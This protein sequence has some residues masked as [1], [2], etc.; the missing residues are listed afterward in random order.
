[1]RTHMTRPRAIV[2]LMAITGLV[3]AVGL[4]QAS[5][6][7]P[8][9]LAA[10]DLA[11]GAIRFDTAAP[12]ASVHLHAIGPGVVVATGADNCDVAARE[13]AFA[14]SLPDGA[15]R[16]KR[17][18]RGACFDYS[19]T[20]SLAHGVVAVQ[21]RHGTS[22]WS[23]ED[24]SARWVVRALDAPKQAG[25][26]VVG[27]ARSTR[28]VI[29]ESRTGRVRANFALPRDSFVWY[30]APGEAVFASSS[31]RITAVALP[32]GR[33]LWRTAI[34]NE[35]GLDAGVGGDGVIAVG[36]HVRDLRGGTTLWS[37]PAPITTIG[38]GLALVAD[39]TSLTALDV[40]TGALRW[41][42]SLPV[43]PANAER[44]LVAGKGAVAL[45][46]GGLSH[47]ARRARRVDALERGDRHHRRRL[48]PLGRDRRRSPADPVDLVRLGAVRRVATAPDRPSAPPAAAGRR[49]TRGRPRTAPPP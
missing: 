13:L 25:D 27:M 18:L 10:Y 38:S 36:A 20:G 16:W 49:T 19:L 37:S 35:G 9:H 12:T 7:A 5:S 42:V 32:S 29:V 11:T 45:V 21:T 14:F 33:V 44:Q 34:P 6:A 46:E 17:T 2:A 26:A 40:R 31:G 22:G 4:S 28:G 30:T 1:M 48:L 39:E 47:G 8:G 24:G 41:K 3:V 23:V 43:L 15:L